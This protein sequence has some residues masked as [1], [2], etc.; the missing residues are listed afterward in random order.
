MYV[1]QKKE[2]GL[3]DSP[4][5]S[6]H[7]RTHGTP[8]K[9]EEK[10]SGKKRRKEPTRVFP[11]KYIMYEIIEFLF[12]GSGA[13][14]RVFRETR[15]IFLCKQTHTEATGCARLCL[16]G[17][18][19]PSDNRKSVG[20]IMKNGQRGKMNKGR[21]GG[22]CSSGTVQ[23]QHVL[24]GRWVKSVMD[25]RFVRARAM[26]VTRQQKGLF[27]LKKKR[28]ANT[29]HQAERLDALYNG[30]ISPQRPFH[31]LPSRLLFHKM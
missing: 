7:N 29:R 13:F 9:K 25:T 31:Q 17:A 10:N 24:I 11:L 5:M 14:I 12:M 26:D 30:R 3:M 23:I 8:S 20:F 22:S 28:R 1:T 15:R 27:A 18:H 16:P 21:A 2:I 6:I 4:D 19:T